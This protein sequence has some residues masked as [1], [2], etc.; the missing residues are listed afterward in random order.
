MTNEYSSNTM[1]TTAL[2]DPSRVRSYLSKLT[3]I[4]LL[5]GLLNLVVTLVS[6]LIY[7]VVVGGPWNFGDGNGRALTMFWLVLTVGAIMATSLGYVLRSTAA[8][9][10]V[11]ML[12]PVRIPSDRDH[13]S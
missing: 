4:G 6:M 7:T 2:S 12:L 1:R 13:Q 5:T 11:S 10:T 9:I 8:T 3:A